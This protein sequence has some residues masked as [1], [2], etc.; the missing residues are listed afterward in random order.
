M[1]KWLPLSLLIII[2]DQATKWWAISE[3][4]LYESI[5]VFPSFNITLAYNHGAA[6]SFLAGEAG[7]QRWFFVGLA[8][9]VSVALLLWL[10]KLKSHAKLEAASLTLILGGAIG[11]VI[12]RFIHGYVIDFLD[13]YYGSYHWPIFNIADS[14]ICVGA[15]LLII[16]SFRKKSEQE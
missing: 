10:S 2:I 13:V 4:A 15:A 6:F 16:D 7:W 14:A 1:L 8:L 11:N 3:L 12:D 9:V 5:P